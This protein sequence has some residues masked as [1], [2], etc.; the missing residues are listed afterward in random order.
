MTLYTIH[1]L[2]LAKRLVEKGFVIISVEKDKK[3]KGKSL[4]KFEDTIQLRL[5]LTDLTVCF[6]KERKY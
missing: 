2:G 4:F 5:T 6:S 3:V 1:S